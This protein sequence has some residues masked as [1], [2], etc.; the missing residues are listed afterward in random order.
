MK[1]TIKLLAIGLVIVSAAHVAEAGVPGWFG[2]RYRVATDGLIARTII[3]ATVVDVMPKS[4]AASSPI[5]AGD[6]VLEVEGMPIAGKQARAVN[7]LMSKSAGEV[8]HL[9]LRHASG[10]VYVVV[11]TA[12]ARRP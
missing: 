11:L 2:I 6:Q 8:L 10:E 9:R 12:A 4:P 7:A 1:H 5:A 3:S